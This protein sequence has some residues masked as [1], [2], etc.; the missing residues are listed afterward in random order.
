MKKR[1]LFLLLIA[2]LI[3]L[4]PA[5]GSAQ[6]G[7]AA[8]SAPSTAWV[9]V[10]FAPGEQIVRAVTFEGSLSGLEAL[11]AS[12]LEVVTKD[13]GWG[14]AVCAINGV[15]CPADNCFCG[16]SKFWNYEYWDWSDS[17]WEGYP[18]GPSSS[19]VEDGDVEGWRWAE[20]GVGS[21]PPGPA[22]VAAQKAL[23]WLAGQQSATD[24]GY[25]GAGP[26]V[27]TLLSIGANGIQA[28]HWRRT[29]TAPS[30]LTYLMGKAAGYTTNAAAAGKLTLGWSAAGPCLPPF[31]HVAGDFYDEE[32]GAYGYGAGAQAW[33][34]LGEAARGQTIPTQA[35]NY[36]KSRQQSDGGWEYVPGGWGAGTD[37]NTTALALQALVAAGEPLTS[38]VI[39]A[40]LGYLHTAQN[41]DGGFPYDPDS[42][43]G[44]A[45]D[46]NSTAY[47]L[48]A[49]Y[50]TGQN[51]A[52]WKKGT[53]PADP[54]DFLLSLQLEGGA[55]EWQAG[56]G[57][58]LMATQQAIPAL[59]G[60]AF[61]LQIVPL[62]ACPLS[63][64]PLIRR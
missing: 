30:L 63:F 52:A 15:G 25:G 14:V 41:N 35:V 9:A 46:A 20:W 18:V 61:P 57:A 59:L 10:Q 4:S 32:T 11:Q 54:L 24:G 31:T 17:S 26:S 38:T 62:Q 55:F 5:W 23:A 12:G 34:I 56:S 6:P 50:A 22:L 3:A 48:Q 51:L 40:G 1:T 16:G 64:T 21:L 28:R 60:R 47:V 45:S 27:E 43:W 44:T 33:A 42:S 19:T 7:Q 8:P 36:L 2:T 13:F 58:N 39:T 29:P 53:P 49:L 37:T